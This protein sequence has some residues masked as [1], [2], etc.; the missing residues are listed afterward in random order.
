VVRRGSKITI[1]F[2]KNGFLN[3]LA[4]VVGQQTINPSSTHDVGYHLIERGY[5]KNSQLNGLG[6]RR[7]R[8]GNV[9]IGEFKNN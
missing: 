7:F 1:G 8:N 5:Y 9:Y 3:G 2:S 6:E 4:F